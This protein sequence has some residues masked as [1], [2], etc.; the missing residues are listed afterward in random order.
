MKPVEILTN[1]VEEVIEKESLVRKSD[2][3]LLAVSGGVD[4]AVM[5]EL[6][7]QAGFYFGIAHCNFGPNYGKTSSLL[8]PVV[9][10]SDQ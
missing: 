9:V 6:F 10:A 3:T 1:F 4:S 7:H 5:C 8:A 2:K